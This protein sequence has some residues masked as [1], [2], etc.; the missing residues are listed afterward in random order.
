MSE[1]MDDAREKR[2]AEDQWR[3]QC[4]RI[5]AEV[6]EMAEWYKDTQYIAAFIAALS[7]ELARDSERVVSW[8]GCPEDVKKKAHYAA[9]KFLGWAIDGQGS[10]P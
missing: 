6:A 3:R 10:K 5:G 1:A 2:R 7:A 8:S 4:M 9:E